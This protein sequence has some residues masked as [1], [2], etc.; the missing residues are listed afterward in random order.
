MYYL[1]NIFT[2]ISDVNNLYFN[3]VNNDCYLYKGRA[4][5]WMRF[6]E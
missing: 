3:R 2:I 5:K 4:N 1:L 6:V